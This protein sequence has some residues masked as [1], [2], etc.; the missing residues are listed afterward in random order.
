METLEGE[1]F[2]GRRHGEGRHAEHG[3]AGYAEGLATRDE[4]VRFRAPQE[5]RLDHARRVV[6][7]VFRVV[8]DH[9]D[10]TLTPQVG[11]HVTHRSPLD[12][13]GRPIEAA[14]RSG[15]CD[16]TATGASSAHQTPPGW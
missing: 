4:D 10:C 7:D 5:D 9:Q 14:M 2:H 15:T 8:D 6:D 16:P 3:L 1:A 13:E 12:G 11:D